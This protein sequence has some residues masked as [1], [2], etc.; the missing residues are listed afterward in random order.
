LDRPS[1]PTATDERVSGKS[2]TTE[3]VS[4]LAKYRKVGD[5]MSAYGWF[6]LVVFIGPFIVSVLPQFRAFWRQWRALLLGYAAVSVPWILLDALSHA[7]GWWAYEPSR[8]S[9]IELLGLPIEEILFFF[10]VPFACMVVMSVVQRYALPP[11][12]SHVRVGLMLM[13][14]ALA[15]VLLI[16]G[17]ARERSMVDLALFLA[18][19]AL[20]WR[21]GCTQQTAFW[22]WSGLVLILFLI[23]NSILTGLPIVTYNEWFMSGLRIGTIP[24]EDAY[25]NFA[26]LWSFLA[27]FDYAMSKRRA[28]L[29]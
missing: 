3:L 12:N 5:D 2:Q 11:L 27:V 19:F 25:Y 7:R 15:A 18:S 13:V 23:F 9:S 29:R 21:L 10:T 8:V 26:F 16:V 20:V 22:L 24:V 1:D 17:F 14:G 6:Q 4:C 28:S